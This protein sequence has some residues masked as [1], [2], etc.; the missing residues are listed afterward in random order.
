M[1]IIALMTDFDTRDHYVAVMKGVILQINPKAT[2]VDVSHRIVPQDL[3]HG[4]FVL[5]QAL[6]FFPPKTIFVAVVDP[7]VGTRR[8]IL[9]ARYSDRIVLAPD[10]G[11]LTL[12]HRDAELQEIRV[13]E[14]RRFFAA[15]LST[16]FHGRDIFAPV[17][18][19]LSRNVTLD[20]LGPVADCIEVLELAAP[21]KQKDGG[22]AGQIVVV[23][24][25]GNL[26]TNVSQLDLAAPGPARGGFVVSV[27]PREVGPV[28]VTY[29]DVAPGE[30]L[31]LIGS[32]Q[33]LEIAVNSGN[34]AEKLEAGRGTP[35]TLRR[36]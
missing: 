7:T 5:R 13:V 8:R 14:N 20:Q 25:F 31:A 2:L 36:T 16:T 26:I 18:A 28:R 6:P 24:G 35:V 3:Y 15:T 27:G 23:D 29:G 33:M 1:P 30:P 32:T 21:V 9:A 17:A 11:L 12:L 22:I 4:A 19:H 34:A 10:N